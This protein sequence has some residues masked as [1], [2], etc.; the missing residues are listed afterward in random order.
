M[1]SD[2]FNRIE[3]PAVHC[4]FNLGSLGSQP[5]S[6][7]P[8]ITLNTRFPLSVFTYSVR[9]GLLFVVAFVGSSVLA[10][11]MMPELFRKEYA[12]ALGRLD[13]RYANFHA[14]GS[15]VRPGFTA[16]VEHFVLDGSFQIWT[17]YPEDRASILEIANYPAL[18]VRSKS[19]SLV[20]KLGRNS[21]DEDF[22]I[23]GLGDTARREILNHETKLSAP[24]CLAASHIVIYSMRDLLEDPKVVLVGV[25]QESNEPR[26]VRAE[27]DWSSRGEFLQ[28]G[29][30]WLRPESDWVIDHYELESKP[31]NGESEFFYG[32][33]EYDQFSV[34]QIPFPKSVNIESGKLNKPRQ[35]FTKWSMGNV[36]FNSV[37]KEMFTLEHF[38]LGNRDLVTARD[39]SW[40]WLAIG[41]AGVLLISAGYL[42]IWKLKS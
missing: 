38:G 42:T 10:A 29:R 37:N 18:L 24:L 9:A 36:S 14:S 21:A 34:D 30:V 4:G 23:T 32:E 1:V 3:I 8:I 35:L 40:P 39:K 13:A 15:Q 2:P 28:K 16:L 17:H 12:E 11:E 6:Q 20:F 27:F 26:L 7:P 5:S 19:D 33:V 31:I 22:Y 41:S 25:E